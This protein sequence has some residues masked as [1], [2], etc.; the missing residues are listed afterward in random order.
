MWPVR[1][2]RLASLSYWRQSV[3]SISGTGRNLAKPMVLQD[4]LAHAVGVGVGDQV[5]TA[6]SIQRQCRTV[7]QRL[8][9]GVQLGFRGG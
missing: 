9:D 6:D 3:F 2:T 4:L 5:D 7:F 8:C 1:L